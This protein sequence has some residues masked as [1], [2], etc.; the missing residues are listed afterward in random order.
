MTRFRFARPAV[1]AAAAALVAGLMV[2]TP[3]TSK[4]YPDAKVET[5]TRPDFGLLL[6]PPL[7]RRKPHKP[8]RYRDRGGY[9]YGYDRYPPDWKPWDGPLRDVAFVDCGRARGP[10]EINYALDSLAPGGTL[11]IRTRGAPCLDSIRITKPV[12]IQADGGRPWRG[13]RLGE[14]RGDWKAL[15]PSL[16]ARAG[17]V[18][19]AIAP[20]ATGEVIL[21]NLV[22]ESTEGGDQPCIY[23]EGANVRLESTVVR[24]AGE[25]AAIYVEGGSF[26]ATED[27][28]VDANTYDRAVY[29]E[30]SVLLLRDFTIAGTP[31]IGLDITPSGNQDSVLE[32]VVFRTAP[33]SPV[34]GTPTVGIAVSASRTL[35]RLRISRARI[36]GFGI[37][38][39]TQ[40]PNVVLMDDSYICRAG[41]GIQAMG[42]DLRVEDTTIASNVL[43]LQIGAAYPVVLNNNRFYGQSEYNIFMEPGA[44]RPTGGGNLFYANGTRDCRWRRMDKR[45]R[46]YREYERERKRR[47]RDW[48]YLPPVHRLNIGRCVDPGGFDSGYFGYDQA[49]G[50]D[51]PESFYRASPWKREEIWD[52]PAAAEPGSYEVDTLA[53]PDPAAGSPAPAEA[54]PPESAPEEPPAGAEAPP[55]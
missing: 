23:S 6:D 5:Q 48:M 13:R 26:E 37:G 45:H 40:G 9:G 15:P 28:L 34:F 46:A 22:I 21:R 53:P 36:C 51:S 33:A 44:R 4:A 55:N 49:F 17:Q 47:R 32:D 54:L 18:C 35:G 19:I 42:G 7:K 50:Y 38:L 1:F 3:E 12:T 2:F 10:N 52:D 14:T 30:D 39:W 20:I 8:R 31:A 27:S 25:G 43:G 24:Y 11:I 16:R 41:K 29:A